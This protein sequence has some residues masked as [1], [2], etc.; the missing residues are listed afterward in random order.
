M[1]EVKNIW[2]V[3]KDQEG[4]SPVIATIL[5][6]AITVV[7]AAVLYVMVIDIPPDGFDVDSGGSIEDIKIKSS[8]T[9]EIEFGAFQNKEPVYLKL[10]LEDTDGK[11]ISFSWP[12]IPD[13]ENFDMTSSDQ[14]VTAVY[15][16]LLPVG[17]EINSGDSMLITGLASGMKYTIKVIDNE[18]SELKILGKTDFTT[19]S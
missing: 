12:G 13:T 18:G 8:D 19:P 3:R 4:V 9:V 7:L 11:R 6:V 5:M 15:R 16:D 17:N 14:N 1:S 10:M 2:R